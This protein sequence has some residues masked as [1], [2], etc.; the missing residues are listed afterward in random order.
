M[1][2]HVMTTGTLQNPA[3]RRRGAS[4]L[5]NRL[6]DVAAKL[7]S[8]WAWHQSYRQTVRELSDLSNK[9]LDDIGIARCDIPVIALQ[10]AD[11]AQEVR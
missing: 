2:T 10:S 4:P 3:G 8:W 1:T 5:A 11:R 6:K 9:D 7:A